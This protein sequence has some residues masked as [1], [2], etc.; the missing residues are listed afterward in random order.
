MHIL[1]ILHP[2]DSVCRKNNIFGLCKTLQTIIQHL[3]C[4]LEL[5]EPQKERFFQDH[6]NKTYIRFD[7]L[8]IIDHLESLGKLGCSKVHKCI[9][10][11]LVMIPAS[12]T[13][14]VL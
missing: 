10:P 2:N 12:L 1:V 5:M 3:C 4:H 7:I 8:S 14:G 6:Y 11:L 9:N 13:L